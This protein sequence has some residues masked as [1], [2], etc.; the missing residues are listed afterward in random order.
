MAYFDLYRLSLE[1]VSRIGYPFDVKGFVFPELHSR[2]V[3][4]SASADPLEISL[5]LNRK[6]YRRS[7][8]SD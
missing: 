2:N 8:Y 6:I 1:E 5:P 4:F 7:P 3:I